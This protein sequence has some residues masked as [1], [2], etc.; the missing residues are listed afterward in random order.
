MVNNTEKEF[1][2]TPKEL[3]EMDYGLKE[4]EKNG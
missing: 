1:T 3:P 2:L 4:K